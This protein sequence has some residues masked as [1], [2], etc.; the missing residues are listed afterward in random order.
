LEGL[1]SVLFEFVGQSIIFHHSLSPFPSLYF[2]GL[3][4]VGV[5]THK[6]MGPLRLLL[7]V[8]VAVVIGI[9]SVESTSDTN[10]AISFGMGIADESVETSKSYATM[11]PTTGDVY[12]CG[13]FDGKCFGKWEKGAVSAYQKHGQIKLNVAFYRAVSSTSQGTDATFGAF[14]VQGFNGYGNYF[15]E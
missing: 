3:C 4:E 14:T 8:A 6:L 10:W 9:A 15:G 5:S 2:A 11:D 12:T 7:V 13:Q 1:A